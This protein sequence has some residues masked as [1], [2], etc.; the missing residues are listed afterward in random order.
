MLKF[1]RLQPLYFFLRPVHINSL[2]AVK[3]IFVV[4]FL[5]ASDG[6]LGVFETNEGE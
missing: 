2:S 1:Q 4:H 3:N 5:E 6:V